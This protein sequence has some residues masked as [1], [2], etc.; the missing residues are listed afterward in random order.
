MFSFTAAA[1]SAAHQK[2]KQDEE[3]EELERQFEQ[4]ARD[5]W[6]AK[7]PKPPEGFDSWYK[8]HCNDSSFYTK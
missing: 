6:E 7:D 8:E 2:Q 3:K 4:A 5:E 1:A